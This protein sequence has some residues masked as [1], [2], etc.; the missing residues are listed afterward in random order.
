M[1]RGWQPWLWKIGLLLLVLCLLVARMHH[2]LLL[3]TFVLG[4]AG[5]ALTVWTVWDEYSRSVQWNAAQLEHF[6]FLAAAETS[7]DAFALLESVR[8]KTGATVDFRFDYVNANIE[9]MLGRPRREVSGETLLGT[10][11]FFATNGLFESLCGVVESGEPVVGEFAPARTD[12]GLWMRYQAVKL[13][14]G[15][16]ITLSDISTLKATQERYA[17][18]AEFND[19]IFQSA[20]FSIIAT[21]PRGMITAMNLAAERMTGYSREELVG[22]F[23]LTHL[24]DHREL[25]KAAGVLETAGI[26]R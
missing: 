8:D 7:L 5:I 6:R 12:G 22:K 2:G 26:V 17:K 18:L 23:P 10:L 16:A 14:D 3:L 13:G 11:P 24:H 20:P 1:I 19:S 9:K 4:G 15:V 21:D 25:A